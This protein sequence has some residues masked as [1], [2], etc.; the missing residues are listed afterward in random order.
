MNDAGEVTDPIVRRA[1]LE[2]RLV[3]GQAVTADEL[4]AADHAV[5]LAEAEAEAAKE[6]GRRDTQVAHEA[7]L[8][9]I[10][11]ALTD[12]HIEA[13]AREVVTLA[14]RAS[15]ALS[16]LYA[17]AGAYVEDLFATARV[18]VGELP[19]LRRNRV[20]GKPVEGFTVE[21]S[22]RRLTMDGVVFSFPRN[23]PVALVA[24]VAHPVAGNAGLAALAKSYSVQRG[25]QL[26][27]LRRVS[28][29]TPSP[30]DG[31]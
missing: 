23:L 9:A 8:Q 3:D 28:Q 29:A 14:E 4:A 12:G 13:R 2:Q 17:E 16:A 18:L 21:L 1:D 5:R 7:R 31:T 19:E 30:G 22:N 6:R 26:K 25:T 15:A 11:A 20:G 10:R 27:A 24:E